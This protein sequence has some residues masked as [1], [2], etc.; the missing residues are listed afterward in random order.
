MI[1]KIYLTVF[2]N[3][4]TISF[5]VAQ[6]NQIIIFFAD[7]SK[8]IAFQSNNNIYFSPLVSNII[9]INTQNIILANN[10]NDYINSK[11][12][13]KL[14][15]NYSG[16]YEACKNENYIFYYVYAYET[17]NS[18]SVTFELTQDFKIKTIIVNNDSKSFQRYLTE[19][20]SANKDVEKVVEAPISTEKS[21][22]ITE[23]PS[24]PSKKEA[25]INA[26]PSF[27]KNDN[28]DIPSTKKNKEQNTVNNEESTNLKKKYYKESAENKR[29]NESL[30]VLTKQ[31]KE[32]TKANEILIAKNKCETLQNELKV[33]N[34]KLKRYEFQADTIISI[35]ATKA[36]T[37]H[38][39]F[40]KIK[41]A[42][43]KSDFK[44]EVL[45]TDSLY[46]IVLNY[47]KCL[48]TRARL[49][50]F[51]VLNKGYGDIYEKFGKSDFERKNKLF[52]IKLFQLGNCIANAN[53]NERQ[54]IAIYSANLD[55]FKIQK[56]INDI[57]NI[58]VKANG[59]FEQSKPNYIE[60]FK[61][62]YEYEKDF[63]VFESSNPKNE[64]LVKAKYSYG[65][66]LLWN[67]GNI[68][69]NNYNNT[70]DNYLKG[71]IKKGNDYLLEVINFGKEN[72]AALSKDILDLKIKSA[73]VLSKHFEK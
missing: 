25:I 17:L 19:C 45:Y 30:L 47:D 9:D 29:L 3:I 26:P 11:S 14:R 73:I 27:P 67:L 71:R 12:F 31:N 58:L 22:K 42:N 54:E 43:K 8:N 37:V 24:L 21:K 60:A 34:E 7:F 28:S 70:L 18:K 72:P 36:A 53:Y 50:Y 55:N 10:V 41:N 20:K 46:D 1:K 23:V 33:S 56:S 61:I 2:L 68:D 44:K 40:G 57:K 64:I 6:S 65:T 35:C 48:T 66:I 62:Y 69:A 16:K 5:S 51:E 52:E 49:D 32:L 15:F 38:F 13:K 39:Y 59:Y 4:L 63:K